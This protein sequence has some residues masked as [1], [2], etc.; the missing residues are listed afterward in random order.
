MASG[1]ARE[2]RN[3]AGKVSERSDGDAGSECGM[4]FMVLISSEYPLL[5][6]STVLQKFIIFLC[7][8]L[9]LIQVSIPV[10]MR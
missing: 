10:D 4:L 8:S 9:T 2:T 7:S 3:G 1:Y 5:F 6:S